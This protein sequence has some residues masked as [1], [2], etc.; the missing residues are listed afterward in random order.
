MYPIPLA[1]HRTTSPGFR[2]WGRVHERPAPGGCAG[3]ENVARV[4]PYDRTDPFDCNVRWVQLIADVF[5]L[6]PLVVHV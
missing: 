6:H 4:E 1:L 5:M 2:N 3:A